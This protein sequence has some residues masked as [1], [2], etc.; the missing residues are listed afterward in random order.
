MSKSSK[1]A[2]A[3]R[4]RR[5]FLKTVAL[6]AGALALPGQS[7]AA[8]ASGPGGQSRRRDS[9]EPAVSPGKA[10]AYPRVF[11]DDQRRMLAFPLGGVGAGSMSLGGRG[12]LREWW[13]FN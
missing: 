1:K 5:K 2:T 12:D 7:T 11:R 9:S 3:R 10:I 4:S 13:I 8:G 6:G